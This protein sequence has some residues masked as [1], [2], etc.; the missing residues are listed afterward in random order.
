MALLETNTEQH[1]SSEAQLRKIIPSYPKMLDKRIRP[2]LDWYC[3]ELIDLSALIVTAYGHS[4]HPMKLLSRKDVFVADSKTIVLSPDI[5]MSLRSNCVY[6]SLY[7]L[8]PGVGHGLRVNGKVQHHDS[9]LVL[10]V[11]GV[12]LHCARAAARAE[13]WRSRKESAQTE[14]NSLMSPEQFIAASPYLMLKTMNKAGETEL[15]PRGDQGKIAY[16]VDKHRLFI[17]ERPGNKVAISLRNILKNDRVELLMLIPETAFVMHVHGYATLIQ[18]EQ[19]LDLVVVNNKRPKLGILLEQCHFS[20]EQSHA[21]QQA[22]PWLSERQVSPDSLTRFSKALSMHMNGE[23]LLGKAA[24]PIID[25]VV[26]ND[27]KN[28]Y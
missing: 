23:G 1:I 16:L 9:Q 12:Y 22:Q 6:A 14:V 26:K 28:L 5:G 11:S 20:I 8:V 15:S 25:A 21:I 24:T 4:N 19:L 17:P 27:M 2:E 13:L 3:L 10:T 18:N 7:F